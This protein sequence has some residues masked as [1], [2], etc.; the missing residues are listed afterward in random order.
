M[1]LTKADICAATP[2]Y[3]VCRELYK[4]SMTNAVS[5]LTLSSASMISGLDLDIG[6]LHI[7]YLKGVSQVVQK[8]LEPARVHQ[9]II[10]R[11]TE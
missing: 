10:R 8:Q 2:N 4:S 9:V 11:S 7:F 6:Y 1:V 3:K 5:G